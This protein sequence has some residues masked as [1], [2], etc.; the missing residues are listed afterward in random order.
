M[1]SAERY[2]CHVTNSRKGHELPA[3]VD[4]RMILSFCQGVIFTKL[5]TGEVSR[6]Y[7]P[8]EISEFTVFVLIKLT[9]DDGRIS[10]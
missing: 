9:N 6:N 10:V 3:S 5:C 7:T 4:D 2:T 8:R 1:N